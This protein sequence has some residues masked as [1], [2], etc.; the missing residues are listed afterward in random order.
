M[1][2]YMFRTVPLSIIMSFS[3][4]TQQWYMSYRCADSLLTSCQHTC[5]KHVEFHSK[6]KFEKLVILVGFVIRTLKKYSFC[7][8]LLHS[9]VTMHGPKNVKFQKYTQH[10][11]YDFFLFQ[12]H[13]SIYVTS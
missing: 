1:K 3:L 4:Y 8:S 13:L 2:I 6:N 7:W 9:Y 5:I 12:R 11:F 10:L